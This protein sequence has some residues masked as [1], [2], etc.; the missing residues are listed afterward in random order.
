MIRRIAQGRLRRM[1]MIQHIG[2]KNSTITS[3]PMRGLN[4]QRDPGGIRQ[5]H[6]EGLNAIWVRGRIKPTRRIAQASQTGNKSA[7]F[8]SDRPGIAFP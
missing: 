7:P 2:P 5:G 4:G 8:G 6:A 3:Q 1:N